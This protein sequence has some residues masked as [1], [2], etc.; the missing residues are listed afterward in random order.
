MCGGFL[1]YL[2]GGFLTVVHALPK[3]NQSWPRQDFTFPTY[4]RARLQVWGKSSNVFSGG[5][6]SWLQQVSKLDCS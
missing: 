6:V 5:S 3:N 1:S 4:P 2:C